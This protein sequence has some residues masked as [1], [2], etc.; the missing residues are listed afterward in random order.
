MN[1]EDGAREL[2]RLYAGNGKKHLLTPERIDVLIARYDRYPVSALRS[3][4]DQ[5]LA[6]PHLPTADRMDAALEAAY[7][8]E[9]AKA[10]ALTPREASL[11][12]GGEY[13]QHPD[14]PSDRLYAAMNGRLMHLLFRGRVLPAQLPQHQAHLDAAWREG[15]GQDWINEMDR[16]FGPPGAD[17]DTP[18][19]KGGC[20]GLC[21]EC[22]MKRREQRQQRAAQEEDALNRPLTAEE[23][24]ER[25]RQLAMYRAEV[26]AGRA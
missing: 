11:F 2:E 17:S 18:S 21:R 24:Q 10:Q 25:D 4:V 14:N 19:C 12:S 9:R 15:W 26:A 5:L 23:E 8:A 20:G 22:R 1:L 16:Q 7:Q 3:A 13:E 6:D